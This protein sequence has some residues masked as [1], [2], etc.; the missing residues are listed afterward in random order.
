MT[1]G[2]SSVWKVHNF[3]MS[4]KTP[5]KKLNL[6]LQNKRF[7]WAQAAL[8]FLP[9]LF[10]HALH[11]IFVVLWHRQTIHYTK[12]LPMLSSR[13]W[14]FCVRYAPQ[15]QMLL[16]PGTKKEKMQ[17]L[18]ISHCRD[19]GEEKLNMLKGIQAFTKR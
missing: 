4:L 5:T 1:Y 7:I 18:N 11:Q 19:N 14:G 13:L 15:R 2:L 9:V 16:I 12:T 10:L 6:I 17:L 3:E 8:L